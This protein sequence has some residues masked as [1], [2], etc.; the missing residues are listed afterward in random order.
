MLSPPS[1]V[2]TVQAKEDSRINLGSYRQKEGIDESQVESP[3]KANEKPPM[4]ATSHRKPLSSHRG[5]ELDSHEMSVKEREIIEIAK[6][7]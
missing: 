1:E 3:S 2:V 4:S 5:G 7:I 6:L